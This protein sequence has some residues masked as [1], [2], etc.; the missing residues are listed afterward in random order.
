[1]RIQ[2][3]DDAKPGTDVPHGTGRTDRPSC[4]VAPA[5]TR[6]SNHHAVI[7]G[8]SMA[9]LFT[10]RVLAD[11]FTKVTVLDRD[12]LP[13]GGTAR[14]GVPQG[15]HAHALLAAGQRTLMELFPGIGE[16]LLGDGATLINFNEGRW[17]QAGG[18]RSKINKKRAAISASRPLLEH[19]LRR[20]VA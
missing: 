14:K 12:E 9:G 6:T 13:G 5:M 1:M 2:R 4:C 17:Y 19:H 11:H 10:A 20:R 15:R 8:A 3:C 18:Y 16:E 7:V